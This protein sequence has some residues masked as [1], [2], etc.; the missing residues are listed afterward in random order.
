[1][2]EHLKK[3]LERVSLQVTEIL[4]VDGE[5][6]PQLQ[7]LQDARH[8]IAARLAEAYASIGR[9]D[10][11]AEIEPREETRAEY[12]EILEA[13]NRPDDEWCSCG[14]GRD[15]VLRDVLSLRHGRVMTARRCGGCK[16]LNVTGLPPHI[17]EQ[18]AH[19]AKAHALVAG[20]S[21]EEA[22]A[23]LTAQ[24]HTAEKLIKK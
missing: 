14:P 23:V 20:K 24:G 18:R 6:P 4:T 2:V 15:Y 7:E 13:I 5:A 11:A 3:D 17:A 10:L 22:K 19:R 12:V 21:P 16:L 9:F 1:M 8:H